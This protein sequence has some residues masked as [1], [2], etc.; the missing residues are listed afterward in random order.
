MPRSVGYRRS[1][2][3]TNRV[4]PQHKTILTVYVLVSDR[5]QWCLKSNRFEVQCCGIVSVI[6][7][8]EKLKKIHPQFE[9][10]LWIEFSWN[11]KCLPKLS[12]K[13]TPALLANYGI[14]GAAPNAILTEDTNVF[15][16]RIDESLF[17][18]CK[19]ESLTKPFEQ[20]SR[21]FSEELSNL[22]TA[23]SKAPENSKVQFLLIAKKK[24]W[25]ESFHSKSFHSQK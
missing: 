14:T 1:N 20:A 19:L 24:Q 7:L 10:I 17:E 22:E 23:I 25:L 13:G 2:Y 5:L 8:A 16:L 3:L 15:Y 6:E 11:S 18:T 9:N 12:P 4:D 21:T